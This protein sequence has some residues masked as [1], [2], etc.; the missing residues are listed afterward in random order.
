MLSIFPDLFTYSLVAPFILRI[1]VGGF[2]ILQGTRRHKEDRVVWDTF[3]SDKKIGS[4]AI[5]PILAKIQIV[6]GVFLFIGLF[7]QIAATLA[8]IFVWGEWFRKRMN[9]NN[10]PF[11]E[12][13]MTV[14]V[15]VIGISLLF[16]GAGALAIDLPL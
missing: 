8:A 9:G 11:Q 3:W 1:A 2:F 14:L 6:V 10:V 13:W 16:L 12:L 4:H 7:T 5:A 15:S